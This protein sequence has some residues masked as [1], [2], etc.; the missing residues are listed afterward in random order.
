MHDATKARYSNIYCYFQK[1][2]HIF[3]NVILDYIAFSLSNPS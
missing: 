2:Q 3:R 1:R